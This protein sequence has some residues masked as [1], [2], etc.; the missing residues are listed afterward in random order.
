MQNGKLYSSENISTVGLGEIESLK[1][2]ANVLYTEGKFNQAVVGYAYAI[3]QYAQMVIP[4]SR[5]NLVNL[6]SASQVSQAIRDAKLSPKDKTLAAALFNNRSAAYLKMNRFEKAAL[7]AGA[8]A[9]IDP[10]NFKAWLR[11]ATAHKELGQWYECNQAVK[12][13]MR[14]DETN[15][16]ILAMMEE[17]T[18]KMGAGI[19]ASAMPAPR[20]EQASRKGF[21]VY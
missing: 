11:K 16:D 5:R 10:D 19:P 15:E 17:S 3:K 13:A 21:G 7:D 8:A 14:L 18:F 2:Q 1:E 12:N 6:D 4:A 9:L 20:M